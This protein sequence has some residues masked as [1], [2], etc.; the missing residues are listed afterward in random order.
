M[1]ITRRPL[2]QFQLR[3]PISLVSIA[4]LAERRSPKPEVGGSM[5]SRDAMFRRTIGFA[6]KVFGRLPELAMVPLRKRCRCECAVWVRV[7][8]LPPDMEKCQ[9]GLMAPVGNGMVGNG[10]RVRIAIS[11]PYFQILT[12]TL[13]QLEERFATNEEAGGSNPP[14]GSSS[15]SHGISPH[16][17]SRGFSGVPVV[18]RHFCLKVSAR[19]LGVSRPLWERKIGSSNLSTPTSF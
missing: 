18:R 14:G 12:P 2:V 16:P 8:H 1:S 19:R 13:A 11:P 5:P 9:R 7:L 4:Q 6:A 3:V 17:P 15:M 10:T